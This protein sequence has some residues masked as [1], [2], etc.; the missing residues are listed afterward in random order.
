MNK[1]KTPAQHSRVNSNREYSAR[2]RTAV[3][4]KYQPVGTRGSERSPGVDLS[5]PNRRLSCGGAPGSQT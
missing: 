3:N 5:A 4:R 2:V 1:I